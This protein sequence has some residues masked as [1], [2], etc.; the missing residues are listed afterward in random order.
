MVE[1]GLKVAINGGERKK[2]IICDI[3]FL[4]R[5]GG[6]VAMNGLLIIWQIKVSGHGETAKRPFMAM[7]EMFYEKHEPQID[8]ICELRLFTLYFL[9]FLHL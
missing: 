4:K 5:G 8:D 2:I 1:H 3:C 7:V 6:L 9:L